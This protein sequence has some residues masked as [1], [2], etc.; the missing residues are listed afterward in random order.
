MSSEFDFSAFISAL[1]ITFL[2]LYFLLYFLPTCLYFL[3]S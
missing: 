2:S 1:L 3:P